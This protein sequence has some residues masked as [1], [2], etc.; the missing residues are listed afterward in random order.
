MRVLGREVI[1]FATSKHSDCKDV[2]EAWLDDTENRNWQ[3][4]QDVKKLYR[5]ASILHGNFIIFNI[6]GKHYRLAIKVAYQTGIVMIKWFGTHAEYDKID[7][8]R[9]T[10]GEKND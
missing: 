1:E 8:N 5:A 7:W 6:K 3:S 4:P 2:L 9:L 10:K